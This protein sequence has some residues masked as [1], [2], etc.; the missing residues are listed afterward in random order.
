MN[1]ASGAFG[2]TGEVKTVID[3]VRVF[4]EPFHLQCGNQGIRG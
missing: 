4:R 2:E 1:R 3:M